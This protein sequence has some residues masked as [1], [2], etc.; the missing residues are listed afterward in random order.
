MQTS[1]GG[2]EVDQSTMQL[3][4]DQIEELV[5]TLIEEIRERPTVAL[6]LGAALI[7]AIVGTRLATRARPKPIAKKQVDTAFDMGDLAGI[8]VKLMNNP[9]VRSFVFA[10]LTRV[11]RKRIGF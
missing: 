11:V 3:V 2:S 7:G 6:A 10:M 1:F 9:L 4:I 8:G 5:V